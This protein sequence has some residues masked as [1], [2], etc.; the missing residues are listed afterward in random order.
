MPAALDLDQIASN[1]AAR[2]ER[3][4]GTSPLD[5]YVWVDGSVTGP[6]RGDE[7]AD[8]R[9]I[10]VFSPNEAALEASEIRASIERGFATVDRSPSDTVAPPVPDPA[11]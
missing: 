9:A 1:V 10:A 3:T 11:Q 7:R 8:E 4:P 5:V 2:L 6:P